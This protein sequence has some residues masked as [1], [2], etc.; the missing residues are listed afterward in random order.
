[1]S[2]AD[3]P[4]GAGF[5]RNTSNKQPTPLDFVWIAENGSRAQRREVV[6][7][8]KRYAAQGNQDAATVL[9]ELEHH[10]R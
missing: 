5:G 4:K 7:K 10:G 1:M 9:S 2:H 8:L 6:K 3:I